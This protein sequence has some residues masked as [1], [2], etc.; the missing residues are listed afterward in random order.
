MRKICR[1]NALSEVFA[2]VACAP[3]LTWRPRP[4][5]AASVPATIEV[6]ARE[7]ARRVLRAR[8]TFPAAPGP[9]ALVYPKW[10]PGEHAPTGPINDL[11]GIQLSVGGKPIA[12]T[13]DAEDMYQIRCEL[14]A[15]TK[16]LEARIEYITALGTRGAGSPPV[17][18]EQ[19]VVLKWNHVVLYPKGV[20]PRTYPVSAGVL[21]PTGWSFG[22][23]LPLDRKSG[24]GARF[25]AV[26]LETL[27][28][29]PLAAGAHG[30]T[31]DLSPTGGPTHTL[32][33]F[34]DSPEALA[35]KDS[36]QAALERLVSEAG[37]L[38]SAW[39]YR[40]YDFL[41]SLSD[42]IPHGGLEHHESSDNRLWERTLLDDAKWVTRAGLLPHEMVHSWNGK[43]RRPAGLA[44]ADY[45]QPMK[46]ELLW[47]YEGLTS[48]LGEVL[49]A[50]AG[51]RSVADARDNLALTAATLDARP[52]RAWRSLADTAV[53][54]PVLASAPREW[55]AF[56]RGLD[57]Y[58]ESQLIWLEGDVLIRQKT[59]G[60]RTLDDFCQSFFGKTA[61]GVPA[62]VPYAL[63][64]VVAALNAVCP[65][66][67]QGFFQTRVYETAPRA[68][69]GGIEQA[70]W[71]LVYKDTQTAYGKQVETAFKELDYTFSLGLVLNEDGTVSDVLP[72]SPAGKAGL[73]PA[74]KVLAVNGRRLNRD[75]LRAAVAATRNKPDL[76][77]I[78]ES[79]EFIRTYRLAYKGGNRFPALDRNPARPD[80]LTPVLSP[81]VA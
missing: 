9:F 17:A 30:R 50:R 18:S 79:S 19:L 56:R 12:W 53:A 81:R 45:Q 14:P 5:T 23:A 43:H 26:S 46:T 2:L 66:D 38:F 39:P 58:P 28:D 78:V 65:H 1:R 3:A 57:Y 61:K 16:S 72:A 44:T 54:A 63:A 37:S 62:V 75:V 51:M 70:G 7:A 27:I 20:D 35:M 77:L 4:A 52:G 25:K 41:L 15:G 67:W 42:H 47:V 76:E 13:R 49:A 6:D 80:L 59:G 10:L 48:Y 71:R 34:A 40:K 55:R 31:F 64:D 68:P 73:S 22:S 36:T 69:L 74:A 60:K 21:L 8:M 33:V 32:H 29:S 24:E 11:V